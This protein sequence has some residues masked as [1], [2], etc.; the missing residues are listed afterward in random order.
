LAPRTL[1]RAIVE[2]PKTPALQAK[3]AEMEAALEKERAK[4]RSLEGSLSSR[5]MD[6]PS[7]SAELDSLKAENA[8]LRASLKERTVDEARLKHELESMTQQSFRQETEHIKQL[9]ALKNEL[10]AKSKELD[11]KIAES[12]AKTTSMGTLSSEL[13]MRTSMLEKLTADNRVLLED[14]KLFESEV[15]SLT[16]KNQVLQEQLD[17]QQNHARESM[18]AEP[19]KANAPPVDSKLLGEMATGHSFTSYCIDPAHPHTQATQQRVLVFYEPN[20]APEGHKGWIC[21]SNAGT[22][23]MSLEHRIAVNR[24]TQLVSKN[25]RTPFRSS[26]AQPQCCFSLVGADEDN[27]LDLEAESELMASKWMEGLKFLLKSSREE[28]GTMLGADLQY[29]NETLEQK[30]RME[31]L[32]KLELVLMHEVEQLKVRKQALLDA[33]PIDDSDTY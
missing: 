4:V 31:E 10:K 12:E 21:W 15:T 28:I 27:V 19:P 33:E 26:R 6:A 17:Q 23:Q 25:S 18:P 7:S 11:A 14:L 20:G 24:F 29:D 2:D 1:E 22:R 30:Q 9:E 16:E 32:Q 8:Q 5:S 3:L 13:Q